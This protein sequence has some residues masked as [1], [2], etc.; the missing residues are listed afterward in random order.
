VVAVAGEFGVLECEASFIGFRAFLM[1]GEVEDLL[2]RIMELGG[3][4]AFPVSHNT[5]FEDELGLVTDEDLRGR[6]RLLDCSSKR[7]KASDLRPSP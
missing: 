5:S 1:P 3:E 2:R 4:F 6:V 7:F